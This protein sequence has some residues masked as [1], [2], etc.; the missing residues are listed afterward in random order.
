MLFTLLQSLFEPPLKAP[1]HINPCQF[2]VDSLEVSA[3]LCLPENFLLGKSEDYLHSVRLWLNVQLSIMLI[4][5][6]FKPVYAIP[7]LK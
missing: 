2:T 6:L 1:D 5:V 4:Q 3:H 7:I